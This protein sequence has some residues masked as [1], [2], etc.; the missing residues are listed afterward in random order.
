MKKVPLEDGWRDVLGKALRGVG[1]S[2]CELSARAGIDPARVESLLGGQLDRE[3][4]RACAGPL[5]LD[6]AKLDALASG[7]YQAGEVVP[8][9]GLRV[10]TTPFGDMLVNSYLIHD[11]ASR[12]AA[13]FDTGSD[14]DALLSEIARLDLKLESIFL[15]HSHG[16][17]V[18]ELDRLAEKTGA[19]AWI[20][21][22]EPLDGARPFPAGTAFRIGQ[23]HI[24]TRLTWGHS[25]GG[26]TYVVRGLSRPVAVV[27]DALFAGSI[28]GPKVDLGAAIS[29]I[30]EHILSLDDS[31]V[32]C[33][34][35]GPLTTVGEQK[36]SNPFF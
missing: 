21:E 9:E 6:P 19:T 13:A 24:E 8:P 31:T 27:G 28:G 18:I 20:S 35:H 7:L 5:G 32:L 14:C 1:L 26:I 10:D 2:P 34:G 17:H 16:D 36:K 12:V 15:T 33:P 23:L 22:R 11:P 30:S 4:L 25:P 29:T 3:S